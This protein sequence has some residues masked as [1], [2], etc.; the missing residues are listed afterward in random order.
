MEP[1][2]A[3]VY[4]LIALATSAVI[5]YRTM[6]IPN[7]LTFSTA[8]AGLLYNSVSA[9]FTGLWFGIGGLFAGMGCLIIPYAIGGMGAGDVK[10]MGAI[11]AFI[12]YKAVFI[13]FLMTALF[14]GIYGLA[15]LI[16]AERSFLRFCKN[17]YTRLLGIFLTRK[18][19]LGDGS[20]SRKKPRL[21]Y[22]IAIALGGFTY[23]GLTYYRHGSF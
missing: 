5:D 17:A 13:V 18:L 14:G 8:L 12:G 22:G 1:L 3:N 9:G 21:C 11:G 7:Y 2:F 16:W 4:L 19:S 20:E 15:A 6:K 23:I 10:L